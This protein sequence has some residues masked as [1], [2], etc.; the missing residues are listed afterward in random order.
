MNILQEKSECCGDKIL[1]FGGKRR[2]CKT[3][4]KTWR[5]KPAKRGR[6]VLRKQENYLNKVFRDN[7]T[8]KQLATFS[9]LPVETIYKRFR[10]NLDNLIKKC[11]ASL[12]LVNGKK[13]ED[14][15]FFYFSVR[16]RYTKHRLGKGSQILYNWVTGAMGSYSRYTFEPNATLSLVH[17]LLIES[18]SDFQFPKGVD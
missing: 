14:N 10:G 12:N 5:I 15:D 4:R 9:R 6:K 3:C 16:R 18:I 7:F 2:C 11:K 8:V 17:R 1:R 13:V